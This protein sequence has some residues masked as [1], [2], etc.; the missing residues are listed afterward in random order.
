MA[1]MEA[2]ME[3]IVKATA[4]GM[5][6]ATIEDTVEDMMEEGTVVEAMVGVNTEVEAMVVVAMV[7]AVMEV[8]DMAEVATR[9]SKPRCSDNNK[10]KCNASRRPRCSASNRHRGSV[11]SKRRCTAV[12][13]GTSAV[14]R[15]HRPARSRPIMS[16]N[17][18]ITVD[19]E[20]R[21]PLISTIFTSQIMMRSIAAGVARYSSLENTGSAGCGI[22]GNL[23]L[24]AQRL[25]IEAFVVGT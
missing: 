9:T 25:T 1:A 7:A 12:T 10:H 17:L 23:L 19:Q 6:E 20:A 15:D 18:S 4:L 22:A 11:S 5:V 21:I 16:A 2:A 14:A 24:S 3:D 13:K 8:E